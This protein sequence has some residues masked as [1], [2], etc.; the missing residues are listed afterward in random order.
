M[1][2]LGVVLFHSPVSVA[3]ILLFLVISVLYY[4]GYSRH[5]QCFSEDEQ[6]VMFSAYI[7]NGEQSA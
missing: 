1:S 4:W 2:A 5:T 7:I 3:V 6:K